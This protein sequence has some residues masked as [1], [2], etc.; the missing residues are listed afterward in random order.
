[1]RED[2]RVRQADCPWNE[3]LSGQRAD[4]FLCILERLGE[5]DAIGPQGATSFDLAENGKLLA[6]AAAMAM[7]F[8]IE[9]GRRRNGI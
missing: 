2:A 6:V 4:A 7:V 3:R 5:T 9:M 8:V 1:M